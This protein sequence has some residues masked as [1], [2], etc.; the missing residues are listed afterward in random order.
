MPLSRR[1]L[2]KIGHCLDNALCDETEN[3]GEGNKGH[4]DVCQVS[5]F[6]VRSLDCAQW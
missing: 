4:G 5:G 2:F 3:V 1:D 6:Y